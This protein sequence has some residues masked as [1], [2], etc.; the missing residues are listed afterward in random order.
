MKKLTIISGPNGSGKTHL[1]RAF[2]DQH[3]FNDCKIIEFSELCQIPENVKLI[4]IECVPK[5][6]IRSLHYSIHSV[7]PEMRIVFTTLNLDITSCEFGF[8]HII[9]LPHRH[10]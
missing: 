7:N 4:V 1:A 9:N 5:N 6:K 8:A 10:A 2:A 3:H